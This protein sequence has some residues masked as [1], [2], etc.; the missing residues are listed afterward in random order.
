M[1][2]MP[3]VKLAVVGL[4]IGGQIHL[5]RIKDN[6]DVA[7]DALIAPDRPANRTFAEREGV[8]LFQSIHDCL[9]ER[10][11]D[12]V[13]IASP[14]A[15]HAEHARA[16]IDAG[17]AALLEKPITADL[18]EAAALAAYSTSRNARLLIGHHRAHSSFVKAA[19]ETV[20]SGAIGP[21]VS[22]MGSAQFYKPDAYFRDGGWRTRAG[23]GPVLIN[24]I[25]EVDILRR[26]VGDIT[27]VHAVASNAFRGFAVEDTAAI[28]VRF[29]NAALGSFLVSDTAA[30]SASWEQ[31]TKENTAY[32]YYPD[33]C[34]LISG[35]NGSLSLPTMQIKS[36]PNG[37]D[38]SWT[39]PF[40]VRYL[41]VSPA[42]PI[43]E[44][45]RHFVDVIQGRSLPLVTAAD[46]YRNLHIASAILTSAATGRTIDVSGSPA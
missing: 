16:C 4:G 45:L 20:A 30:T 27:H 6:P 43:A 34:Y 40:S 17:V 39:T 38:K 29:G 21:V 3:N 12:G 8:P 13:I 44:Q 35:T 11:V 2:A 26:V 41:P 36:F 18:A 33:D 15:C 25:H 22:V 14:N 5:R 7:L 28:T 37:S 24:F 31:T 1:G 23:G 32:A 46:G 42:D 10:A 9:R 19:A